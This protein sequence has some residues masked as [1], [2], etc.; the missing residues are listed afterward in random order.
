[1]LELDELWS[2]VR[3]RLNKVWLWMALCRR[4]RQIVAFVWGDR[5]EATCKR[6]WRALPAPYQHCHSYSD[7]WRAY[8]AVASQETHHCVGKESGQ[9]AHLERF[10]NTLRQRIGRLV[11]KTLSFSKKMTYLNIVTKCFIT[12]YNMELSLNYLTCCV[13][14]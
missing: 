13:R 2:F 8:A 1:M 14:L 4:S 6:L 11:R 12:L 7:F 3:L 9:T 10:N 5:S